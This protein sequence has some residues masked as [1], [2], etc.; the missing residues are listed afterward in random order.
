MRT[1]QASTLIKSYFTAVVFLT[2]LSVVATPAAATPYEI[3]IEDPGVWKVTGS[4]DSNVDTWTNP[5]DITNWTFTSEVFAPPF[6][7]G[8]FVEGSDSLAIL[9]GSKDFG[10]QLLLVDSE[11]GIPR[12]RFRSRLDDVIYTID[13]AATDESFA[14]FGLS[15]DITNIANVV[16]EPTTALL[17]LTGLAGLAGYRWCHA[18]SQTK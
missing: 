4:F 14:D 5:T 12:S 17:L 7:V 6:T 2:L 11:G 9:M 10:I 1:Q 16:P 13:I 18:R 8:P 15:S 3:L